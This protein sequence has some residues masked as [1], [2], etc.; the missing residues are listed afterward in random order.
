[1]STEY[2]VAPNWVASSWIVKWLWMKQGWRNNC[3]RYRPHVGVTTRAITSLA[4]RV[5]SVFN[6]TSQVLY[7]LFRQCSEYLVENSALRKFEQFIMTLMKM[8]MNVSMQ[9][10]S[11]IFD[12]NVSTISRLFNNVIN[13]MYARLVPLLVFWPDRA[14]LR[15]T[16]PLS[17]RKDFAHC[18]CIIDC[19]QVFIERPGDLTAKGATYSNY[20]HHTP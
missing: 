4:S 1:M 5:S 11:Y 6:N 18:A 20:K 7:I 16:L 8:R 14:T 13:V 15:K 19:F 10:L 3:H 9:Y 17:F 12:V 2:W